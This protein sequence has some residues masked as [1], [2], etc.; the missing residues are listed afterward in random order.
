MLSY[1]G[2]YTAYEL[3]RWSLKTY[4]KR[5]FLGHRPIDSDVSDELP[6]PGRDSQAPTLPL[7]AEERV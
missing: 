4:P 6:T 3:F 2:C 1:N 5:P 7:N